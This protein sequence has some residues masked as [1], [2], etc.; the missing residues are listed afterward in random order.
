MHLCFVLG[1][2]NPWLIVIAKETLGLRCT[3]LSPV[4]RLLMPTFALPNAPAKLT[5]SPSQQMGTLPYHTAARMR[6][7]P[8]F[9]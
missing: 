3:G 2:T 4:L 6:R 9:R 8:H 1:A 7:Y 5:L